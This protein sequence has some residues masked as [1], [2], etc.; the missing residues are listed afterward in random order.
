MS[1]VVK[2]NHRHLIRVGLLFG[3]CVLFVLCWAQEAAEAKKGKTN[4]PA[5]SPGPSAVLQANPN[6]TGQWENSFSTAPLV[7]LSVLPNGNVL[8]WTQFFG[9]PSYTRLWNCDLIPAEN[10]D[11]AKLRCDPSRPGE[12]PGNDIWY[13]AENLFCAGHSF[14]PDGRLL[15]TGG[16]YHF[17]D[18][19]TII[20]GGGYEGIS[21]VTTYRFGDTA[22]TAAPSMEYARWYPSNVALGNGDTLTAAGS[23]CAERN[24]ATHRCACRVYDPNDPSRCQ[25]YAIENALYPEVFHTSSDPTP[26]D[27]WRTLK[28]A[29]RL[30]PLYPWLH[31]ASNGKVF[32]SGPEQQ[33]A[34]LDTQGDGSWT[35]GPIS[36]TYRESGSAVMYD[37]DRVLIAG[38]GPNTPTNTAQTIDLSNEQTASWSF[39]NP[40]AFPRKHHNLTL[41]ADG[42]VLAVGGTKGS[43]FN[44]NCSENIV[45]NAEIWQPAT[46]TWTTMAP[47]S[48]RR[49]YHSTAVLLIDGSVLVGGTTEWGAD[50]PNCKGF[51][52]VYQ[53]EIFSPPYLFNADGTRAARPI[54]TY[55]PSNITYGQQFQVNSPG[56]FSVAK[57]TMVRLPSVTHSIDMNQRINHLSFSRVGG[58][59][60]I[61]AP[62]SGN[63]CP[64]GHYMLFLINSAGVPSIAKIVQIS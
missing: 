26:V 9:P 45:H 13:Y 40:M 8:H 38:G 62:D 37:T 39:T 56:S 44:N 54:I 1:Q 60:R 49:Q 59:V 16:T 47:M 7:H 50:D 22:L 32:Y 61:T 34:W 48:Y 52:N 10:N 53:T 6:Q 51:P 42:S 33:S 4:L 11:P 20:H 27:S 25:Q 24:P 12:G 5:K 31:F 21:A 17:N 58:G 28:S 14:L 36:S 41:L 63:V 23:Y 30:L 46:G 2:L 18:N 3:L 35:D 43:G 15:I 29:E 19:G 57:V 55:A 64:P